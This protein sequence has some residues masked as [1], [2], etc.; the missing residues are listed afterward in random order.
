MIWQ[1]GVALP[2]GISR[3]LAF[4]MQSLS[5]AKKIPIT[6]EEARTIQIS[7]A[8]LRPGYMVHDIGCGSG[9]ISVEASMQVEDS[10]RGHCGGP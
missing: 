3:R 1:E 4:L 9:S 2:C 5:A 8:R 6:K 7:K 10:G